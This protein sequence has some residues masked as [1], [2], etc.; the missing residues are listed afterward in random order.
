MNQ[1]HSSVMI[2]R[3]STQPS[4]QIIVYFIA[5]IN[6]ETVHLR[7]GLEPMRPGLEHSQNPVFQLRSQTW[8][9]D[10]MK[11]RFLMSH[12]RKNSVT[13]KVIGEKCI[14][15]ERNA[16][17]RVWA[18]SEGEKGTR[19]WNCQF[20]QGWVISQSNEWEKYSSY[21][22][23]GRGFLGTGPPPTF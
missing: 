10:L 9:L 4:S 14:Y 22:R 8:F 20:L 12:R 13:D 1:T 2:K 5:G 3:E 21:F 23:K 19:V 17:H 16:L 15:L 18:I 7:L 11:L 6:D